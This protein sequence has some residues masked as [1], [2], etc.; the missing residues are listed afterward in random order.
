MNGD[1]VS[2]DPIE[3]TLQ[4]FEVRFFPY[5]FRFNLKI[6]VYKDGRPPSLSELKS[7]YN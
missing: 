7:D 1:K 2:H 5:V 6:F 4:G 3:I